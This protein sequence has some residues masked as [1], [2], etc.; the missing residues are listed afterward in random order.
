M[1]SGKNL[2]QK[3]QNQ[4]RVI[5]GCETAKLRDLLE[6]VCLWKLLLFRKTD[7]PGISITMSDQAAAPNYNDQAAAKRASAKSKEHNV[8][9]KPK[10]AKQL[11]TKV[12]RHST[13]TVKA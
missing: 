2:R 7:L 4:S 10:R 6:R 8:V 13:H 3:V 5:Y 12:T 11:A 1:R 9:K